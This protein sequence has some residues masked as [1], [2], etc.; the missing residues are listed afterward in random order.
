MDT[1]AFFG[2]FTMNMK[3]KHYFTFNLT[4]LLKIMAIKATCVFYINISKELSTL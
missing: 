1:N 3:G 2:Q 4:K